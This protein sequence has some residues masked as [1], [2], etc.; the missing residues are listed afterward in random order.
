MVAPHSSLLL[1]DNLFN[2]RSERSRAIPSASG[3]RTLHKH[4]TRSRRPSTENEQGSTWVGRKED[5]P[6]ARSESTL[7]TMLT[8]P[9]TTANQID[10]ECAVAD[11]N[12]CLVIVHMID[13]D[14]HHCAALMKRC[15]WCEANMW[16]I[17]SSFR[18]AER[19]SQ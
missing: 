9:T 17:S 7:N 16:Q 4:R 5:S 12:R 19:D 3:V 1:C 18:S 10:R 8:T 13:Q 6:R 2:L 14:T 15:S 11:G